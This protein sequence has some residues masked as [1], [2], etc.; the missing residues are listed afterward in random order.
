M[1]SSFS[2]YQRKAALLTPY[3]LVRI[4]TLK[5][6][7]DKLNSSFPRSSQIIVNMRTLFPCFTIYFRHFEQICKILSFVINANNFVRFKSKM[8]VNILDKLAS[9]I[10][11]L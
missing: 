8:D 6:L 4:V 9:G 11:Y 1:L 5:R 10:L 3:V 7:V 2:P